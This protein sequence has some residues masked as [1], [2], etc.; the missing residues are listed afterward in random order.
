MKFTFMDCEGKNGKFLIFF[1]CLLFPR[2]SLFHCCVF[3]SEAFLYLTLSV[4]KAKHI[5]SWKENEIVRFV[6]FPQ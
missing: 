6:A 2:L 4:I 5:R 3:S 1:L